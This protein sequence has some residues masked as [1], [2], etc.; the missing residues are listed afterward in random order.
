MQSEQ[1]SVD[2]FAAAL[3]RVFDMEP[4]DAR[5]LGEVVLAQFETHAEVPDDVLDSELRSVFYTLESK[6]M[7]S[8]RRVEFTR[9][10]GDRRR[11]FYWRLRTEELPSVGR[12]VP[13]ERG[14][15]VYAELPADAWRH[16][17]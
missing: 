7:L 10:E 8:F 15:D 12:E 17:S 4:A 2:V 16:A 9:E 11:A 3:E 13:I 1:P 6:R 5:E 14:E